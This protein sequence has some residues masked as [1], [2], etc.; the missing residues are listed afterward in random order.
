MQYHTSEGVRTGSYYRGTSKSKG[1]EG[2]LLESSDHRQ[3]S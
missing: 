2:D 3:Y 1:D